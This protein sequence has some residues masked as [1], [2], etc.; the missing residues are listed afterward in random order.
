[1]NGQVPKIP[2]NIAEQAVEWLIELQDEQ[3]SEELISAFRRWH[4]QDPRHQQAWQ[5]IEHMNGRISLLANPLGTATVK[6]SLGLPANTSRRRLTKVLAFA[7]FTGGTGWMAQ[8]QHWLADHNTAVG[9]RRQ[10]TL[11]DGSELVLNTDTAVSLDF[12]LPRRQL[13][14]HRGEILINT[15]HPNVAVEPLQVTTEH[16][17]LTPLGTKFRVH[18]QAERSLLSVYEGSVGVLTKQGQSIVFQAGEQGWFNQH[19]Y[20]VSEPTNP[21]DLSWTQGTL[22]AQSMRLHDFIEQLSRYHRGILRCDPEVADLNISGTYPLQNTQMI[23]DALEHSLPIKIQYRT[24]Y[25]A[26]LVASEK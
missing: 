14:L 15:G 23:L 11:N 5:H 25:L 2:D 24:R 6:A 10:L 13:Q 12:N 4:D 26:T 8:R 19:S 16:G 9:E 3:H 21:T 20:S 7:L 22:I 18:H 17:T 1:M